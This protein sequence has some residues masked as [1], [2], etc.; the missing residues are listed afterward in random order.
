M[1]PNQVLLQC[2]K[3]KILCSEAIYKLLTVDEASSVYS[4]H[5]NLDCTGWILRTDS[6]LVRF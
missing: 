2:F 5:T 3:V 6:Y 4:R 1:I